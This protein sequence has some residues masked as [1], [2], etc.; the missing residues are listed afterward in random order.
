[1]GHFVKLLCLILSFSAPAACQLAPLA[2][3]S[4]TTVEE[5]QSFAQKVADYAAEYTRQHEQCL[6]NNKADRAEPPNSLICSRSSCQYLH[7]YVFGDSFSSAKSLQKD[8]AACY[9][10]VNDFQAAA[11]QE[12][13]REQQHETERAERRKK[14][15]A[16]EAAQEKQEEDDRA[17]RQKQEQDER[18]AKDRQ[19]AAELARTRDDERRLAAA[20]QAEAA[21]AAALNDSNVETSIT[22]GTVQDSHQTDNNSLTLA[23]PFKNPESTSSQKQDVYSTARMIDPFGP[24][25]SLVDPFSASGDDV[26]SLDR[27]SE[28]DKT[29]FEMSSRA[30]ELSTDAAKAK[31]DQYI[32]YLEKRSGVTINRAKA[33]QLIEGARDTK[34]LIGTLATFV[35]TGQYAVLVKNVVMADSPNRRNE[36]GAELTKQVASDV[37]RSDLV[38]E[39]MKTVAPR[40]FG[41]RVGLFLAGAAGLPVEAGAILLDSVQTDRNPNDVIRDTSGKYS[42]SEKQSALVSMWNGYRRVESQTN[43]GSGSRVKRELWTNSNIVYNEC[44]EAKANCDRW[45]SLVGHN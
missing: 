18:D 39:G 10:H 41:E 12:A 38:K 29:T 3:I 22:G 14:E 24:K 19:S 5:C 27:V 42:L 8:E 30:I 35:S 2:P 23:D 6:A 37:L 25:D 26:G 11:A 21:H 20:M 45:K 34:S 31:L 17:N 36:A 13:D 1:M 4:P 40:L 7:D 15:E 16:E 44:L 28:G 43:N 9:Q 33:S 32:D